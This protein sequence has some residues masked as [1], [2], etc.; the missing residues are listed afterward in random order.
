M[1][2]DEDFEHLFSNVPNMLLYK[3][4]FDGY[5]LV[6]MKSTS[7]TPYHTPGCSTIGPK[8]LV[9]TRYRPKLSPYSLRFLDFN[10]VPQISLS[11][12]RKFLSKAVSN[13]PTFSNPVPLLVLGCYGALNLAEPARHLIALQNFRGFSPQT[14]RYHTHIKYSKLPFDVF[15]LAHGISCILF[16]SAIKCI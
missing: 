5:R 6:Q 4:Y 7:N 15:T 10:S 8:I 1:C 9:R 11:L 2:R 3:L 16:C 14:K 12:P 13:S